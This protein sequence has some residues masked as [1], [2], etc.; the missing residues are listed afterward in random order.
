MGKQIRCKKRSSKIK[1]IVSYILKM[2]VK[3]V[4]VC[5]GFYV[6]I[7]Q[8]EWLVN[9]STIKISCITPWYEEAH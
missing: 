8:L 1:D 5:A 6:I 2:G 4:C 7:T 9:V 3:Y